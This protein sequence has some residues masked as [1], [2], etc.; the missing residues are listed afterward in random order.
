MLMPEPDPDVCAT[1]FY[2]DGGDVVLLY[3]QTN[4]KAWIQSSVFVD[5]EPEG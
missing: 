2:L 1:R 3:D 4:E 5:F